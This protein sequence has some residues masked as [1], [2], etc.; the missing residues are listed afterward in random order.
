MFALYYLHA[1]LRLNLPGWR[2]INS[3][4]SRQ[5]VLFEAFALGLAIVATALG[6]YWGAKLWR[7]ALPIALLMFLLTYY[8][9][10]S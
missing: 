7:I 9:M 4:S 5:W 2:W 1:G 6:L 8:V 10:V 3:L